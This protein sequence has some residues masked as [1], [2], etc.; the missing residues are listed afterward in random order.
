MSTKRDS[1]QSFLRRLAAA[2]VLASLAC[3]SQAAEPKGKTMS[4]GQAKTFLA[5]YTAVVELTNSS[6]ARVAVCPAWQGRVMTSTCGGDDGLSFGFIN[7]EFIAARQNNLHFNNFG[8]EERM[9]LSPEGGQFS[10]W[11]KPGAAQNLDH[12]FTPPAFNEG[13]WK[14]TS[15]PG[16]PS[17]GMA[18]HMQLGN[19]SGAQFDLDATREVRLLSAAN[20]EELFGKSAA[21]MIS[22]AGV[23]SVAYE[24][25]NGVANRGTVLS[26]EKGLLSIWILSMMNCGPQ[27]VA[28]IPYR[29][30]D[31]ATLGPVVKSDYFGPV[32]PERLKITPEAI[33][34]RADGEFRSKL[35]TSQRRARNVLGSIDYANGVLTLAHFTMPEDPTK[36]LYMNN[37]WELPQKQPY[38]GD[39]ANSYNDGPPAPG[40]KGLGAFYE[41]ESLSPAL[42]LKTGEALVHRHRTVHVQGDMALLK[43][44]AKEVLGVDLDAVRKAML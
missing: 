42:P 8:G 18:H 9:W 20:L 5:K 32:P 29:P 4:Y 27:T 33:L 2:V 6:G 25:V 31:E 34:F 24:T 3:A 23:K 19:A 44:L 22:G 10:L 28:I 14:V 11:F 26:K 37:M 16:A 43:R 21:S 12:W 40:K 1:F 30:G 13:G 35:G 38:V 39:V 36:Q 17:V 7:E 41:I 15:A